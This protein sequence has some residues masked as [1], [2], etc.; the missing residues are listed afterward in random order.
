MKRKFE[1]RKW[2]ETSPASSQ[3]TENSST[4][5]AL[6]PRVNKDQDDANGFCLFV[7]DMKQR[8]VAVVTWKEG[9]AQEK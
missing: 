7:W 9:L 4:Q 2:L 1:G 3:Q 5:W 8:L 6:S